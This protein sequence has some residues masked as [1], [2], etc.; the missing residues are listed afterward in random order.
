MIVFVF[1]IFVGLFLFIAHGIGEKLKSDRIIAMNMLTC[2]SSEGD[3]SKIMIRS[4][5][6]QCQRAIDQIE[7][8][9]K[10]NIV[11]YNQKW[12]ITIAFEEIKTNNQAVWVCKG[13]PEKLFP[14]QCH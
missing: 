4:L 6:S 2:L 9:S 3:K 14:H 5:S 12:H 13:T 7:Y 1:A 11:A 10:N 8:P